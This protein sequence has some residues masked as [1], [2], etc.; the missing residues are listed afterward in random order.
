MDSA[1]TINK[2]IDI[3]RR[4]LRPE[5]VASGNALV[6]Q[7]VGVSSRRRQFAFTLPI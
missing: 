2:P 6:L 5:D 3:A 1:E 7:E 4:A